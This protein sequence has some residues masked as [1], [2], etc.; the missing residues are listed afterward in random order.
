MRL[1]LVAAASADYLLSLTDR[2]D[3]G[4]AA[5]TMN[6]ELGFTPYTYSLGVASVAIAVLRTGA[7]KAAVAG[8]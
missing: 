7:K 6:K 2:V 3:V 1:P 4:F 5:L 8:P